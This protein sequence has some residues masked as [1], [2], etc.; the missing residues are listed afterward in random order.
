MIK[1]QI[2]E[3]P[4]K[5]PI[6]SYFL[7][8]SLLHKKGAKLYPY[9]DII[10]LLIFVFTKMNNFCSSTAV[11]KRNRRSDPQKHCDGGRETS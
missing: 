6:D 3:K 10:A 7:P 2:Y 8:L 9:L 4:E 1:L 5:P 11:I